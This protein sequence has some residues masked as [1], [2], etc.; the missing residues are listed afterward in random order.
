[1]CAVVGLIS[2]SFVGLDIAVAAEDPRGG[3]GTRGGDVVF[4]GGVDDCLGRGGDAE[5]SSGEE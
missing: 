4:E 5:G 1:M 2:V 3:V